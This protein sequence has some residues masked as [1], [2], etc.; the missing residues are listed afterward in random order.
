MPDGGDAQ[1]RYATNGPVHLAYQVLGAG[2]RDVVLLPGAFLPMDALEGHPNTARILRRLSA[3]GRVILTDRRG[4]GQSDPL[5]PA[6]RST[7]ED[8]AADLLAVLDAAGSDECVLV[9]HFDI[10]LAAMALA[11]ACPERVGALVLHHGF[12]RFLEGPDYPFGLSPRFF[13]GFDTVLEGG[14]GPRDVLEVAAPTM[15]GDERFRSWFDAAGRRG[16]SPATAAALWQAM[17]EADVR[18]LL[19]AVS[20]PTLVLQRAGNEMVAPPQ[21]RYLA[22]HIADARYVE[23]PGADHLLYSGDVD[24]MLD[25]VDRFLGSE[26]AV[27]AVDRV[28]ATVLFTDIVGST[29]RAAERG[30]RRWRELL[31]EQD[32]LVARVVERFEGRL[33]KTIGVDIRAGIHTGEVERRGDDVGGIAVHIAARVMAEAGSGEVYVSGAVPPLLAGSDVGFDDR[34]TRDLKGVPGTW[35]LLAARV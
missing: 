16:A 1:T 26:R 13:A 4:V 6:A 19:A 18:P 31:D 3:H 9:A 30:D 29:G 22:E 33:V 5:D 32:T 8:W 24:A 28:L 23:L 25:E 34:G 20:C 15:A 27:V 11:A 10:G 14:T 35:Q 17:L 21:G 7:P 2:G 12:A